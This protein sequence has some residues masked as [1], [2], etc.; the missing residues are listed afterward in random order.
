MVLIAIIIGACCMLVYNLTRQ[1]SSKASG[2]QQMGA[3]L[4]DRTLQ[5]VP[6]VLGVVQREEEI[7]RRFVE[8]SRCRIENG[9]VLSCRM[10]LDTLG[11]KMEE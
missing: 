5:E 3:I 7:L 4:G 8:E 11:V 2:Y 1:F 9:G 6:S 10:S